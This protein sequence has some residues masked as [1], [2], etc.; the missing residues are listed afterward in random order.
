[1]VVGGTDEHR[2]V[3]GSQIT[4]G[5]NVRSTENRR[6]DAL[7]EPGVRDEVAIIGEILGH[8]RSDIGHGV[9][10]AFPDPL[11]HMPAEQ[12]VHGVEMVGDRGRM[13]HRANQAELIRHL[14]EQRVEFAQLHARHL[15]ADR[16]VR[17]A[18]LGRRVRLQIPSIQMTRATAQE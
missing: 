16:F 6:P 9:G 11:N 1:M 4:S 2:R 10:L 14:R 7:D 3:G 18:D 17:P 8:H 12:V 15:G 13:R 5:A